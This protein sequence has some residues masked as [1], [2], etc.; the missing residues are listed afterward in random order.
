LTAEVQIYFQSPMCGR[1]HAFLG[2]ILW[3]NRHNNIFW[4]VKLQTS[5]FDLFPFSLYCL[6]RKLNG[7]LVTLTRRVIRSGMETTFPRH[8][9][10][11]WLQ[12]SGL[13][14]RRHD[15]CGTAYLSRGQGLTDLHHQVP[16]CYETSH[17]NI[18]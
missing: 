15:K 11:T 9:K 4:K 5:T 2:L 7:P 14:A 6:C 3:F 12:R 13:N 16:A 18:I 1:L 10:S 8:A 17:R